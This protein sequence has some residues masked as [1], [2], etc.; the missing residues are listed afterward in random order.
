[1]LPADT[2]NNNI[3][4]LVNRDAIES[5]SPAAAEPVS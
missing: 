5:M 2:K 4:I 3:R 1:V